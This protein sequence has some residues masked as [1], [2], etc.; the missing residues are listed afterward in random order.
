[1]KKGN[2]NSND[3]SVQ[4]VTAEEVANSSNQTPNGTGGGAS[5]SIE[6]SRKS[7]V[8]LEQ[9]SLNNIDALET[10]D[11]AP[12][13]LMSDYWSPSNAGESKR[14]IFDRIDLSPVLAQDTGE[15]ID[16]ECAFFFVKENGQV[17]QVRNGS[18]RLVGALQSYSIQRGTALEIKYL[19]KKRNKM[20][21]FMSDNWSVTPLI[22][23]ASAK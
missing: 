13:D 22:I 11:A 9:V 12:V 19:G 8:E 3:T 7:S 15:I 21:A 5:H 10:A 1:M 17:K 14:M 6:V 20:N 18:K 23:N 16:L 2:E 4:D